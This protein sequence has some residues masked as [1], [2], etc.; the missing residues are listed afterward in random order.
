ML[1]FL[2]SLAIGSP[3]IIAA[4]KEMNRALENLSL[5]DQPL[6]YWIGFHI[7]DRQTQVAYSS[8]GSLIY[9]S[10]D[11][12]RFARIDVR[13]GEPSFDNRNFNSYSS[14]QGIILK[15]LP[16][17][18]NELALR[19]EL[20]LGL[21]LAYKG[22]VEGYAEKTAAY[23]GREYPLSNEM[24]PIDI[25]TGPLSIKA[26]YTNWTVDYANQL[27]SVMTEYE[28]LENNLVVVYDLVGVEHILNSEGQLLS[29]PNNLSVIRI[30]AETRA[31]DGSLLRDVRSWVVPD[32]QNLPPITVIHNEIKS[33][34]SWLNQLRT[35]PIEED[36]L[37][38]VLFEEEASVE[39]FRQLLL[40]QLS[41]TPPPAEAPDFS[42]E[43]PR[44]IPSSRVGR[45]LLPDGWTIVDD[46]QANKNVVGSYTYDSE[47]VAPQKVQLVEDGVV[48][49]LLMSRIPRAN[50]NQST[51]HGRSLGR[52]RRVAI[53]SVTT[54]K[55]KRNRSLNHLKKKG[56]KM[57]KQTGQEYILVVK[58][59]EP[60]ALTNNFEIA[61]SGDGPLSGLTLP[62]EVY[63]LYEDGR[64]IPV[65]GVSFVGVDK[66]V[67][68]D[69]VLAGPQSPVIG[70]T[71]DHYGRYGLGYTG[72]I[73]VAW[74]AP[75]V[76]ISEMELRGQGGQELR[77]IPKPTQSR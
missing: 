10:E 27:S 6:P 2:T 74:S 66:R 38:P 17:E 58:R 35:A 11:S 72:G 71:D 37:G 54:V 20:W 61:F 36:Y 70:L 7:H 28:F 29:Q 31:E 44:V 46:A 41:A 4:E 3:L 8:N 32:Q 21:D 1:L 14:N 34:V 19:R 68:R 39:L 49:N 12:S 42:G 60:L 59:V 64:I 51:G 15:P 53:N 75:S 48:T 73:P 63:R 67:L 76:L 13:V 16:D 43:V 22:A 24:L 40:P 56:I 30:E 26:P 9:S 50:F 45:R 23:E 52:D 65:R 33:M 18:D 69:I 25:N 62:L 57:A 5:P 77:I 47:G 55:P